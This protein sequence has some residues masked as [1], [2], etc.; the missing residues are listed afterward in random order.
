MTAQSDPPDGFKPLFRS[1]PF[2]DHNGPFFFR[3]NAEGTF[4]IGYASSPSTPT[5]AA[6]P[7]A[8]C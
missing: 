5:A 3:E 7:T 1:S 4:V 8:A 2:L 6:S